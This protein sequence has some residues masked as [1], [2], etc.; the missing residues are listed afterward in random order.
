MYRPNGNDSIWV[1]L[2]RL[3]W[4]WSGAAHRIGEL[5][6]EGDEDDPLQRQRHHWAGPFGAQWTTNPAGAASND[7]PQWT[8]IFVNG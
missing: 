1:A 2:G 5:P 8:A 6:D 7:L 3:D 4:G